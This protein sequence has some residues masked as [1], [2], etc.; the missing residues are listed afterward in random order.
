MEN[1]SHQQAATPE[2]VWATLDRI[3]EKMEAQREENKR[4]Q[5]EADRR[6]KSWRGYSPASGAR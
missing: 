3:T 5:K 6:M 2:T 1:Q 4:Q